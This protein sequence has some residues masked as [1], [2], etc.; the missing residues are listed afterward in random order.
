MI[1]NYCAIHFLTSCSRNHSISPYQ[2]GIGSNILM[3]S[4]KRDIA[5][6]RIQLYKYNFLCYTISCPWKMIGTNS[7]IWPVTEFPIFVK[8]GIVSNLIFYRKWKI[9]IFW[10]NRSEI[11]PLQQYYLKTS[12]T[13]HCSLQKARTPYQSYFTEIFSIH[14]QSTTKV[15][16]AY[17]F[18][19]YCIQT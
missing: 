8:A 16:L 6:V 19:R 18:S 9:K 13:G 17:V 3:K 2:S 1:D 5:S 14:M 7:L 4:N 12:C 15:L 10:N 11:S